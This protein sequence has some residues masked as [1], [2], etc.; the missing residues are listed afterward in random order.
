MAT[1][2]C[3]EEGLQAEPAKRAWEERAVAVIGSCLD[4]ACHKGLRSNMVPE[5]WS[6]QTLVLL[7]PGLLSRNPWSFSSS[8]GEVGLDLLD[9]QT[10]GTGKASVSQ[11]SWPGSSAYLQEFCHLSLQTDPIQ[12]QGTALQPLLPRCYWG[13]Y[14]GPSACQESTLPLSEVFSFCLLVCLFKQG[15]PGLEFAIFHSLGRTRVKKRETD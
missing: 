14:P 3:P 1:V 11:R 13:W 2:G 5:G 12:C 15:L 9:K 6:G 8:P 10:F 7:H 4:L